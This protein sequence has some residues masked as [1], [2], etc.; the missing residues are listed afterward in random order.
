MPLCLLT[1]VPSYLLIHLPACL[2]GELYHVPTSLRILCQIKLI[3]F[4]HCLRSS[5]F[6]VLTETPDITKNKK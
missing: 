6:R 5:C 1:C 3:T 2:P 4:D